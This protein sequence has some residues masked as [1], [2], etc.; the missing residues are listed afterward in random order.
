MARGTAL[1]ISVFGD[2]LNPFTY[3]PPTASCSSPI[4][5]LSLPPSSGCSSCFLSL[6]V[7]RGSVIATEHNARMG[8]GG[9][10]SA[11]ARIP[12]A[13]LRYTPR[14]VLTYNTGLL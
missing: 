10:A 13:W 4:A 7:S 6:K 3:G 1:F 2:G 12:G 8:A 11:N 9:R 14:R 5:R